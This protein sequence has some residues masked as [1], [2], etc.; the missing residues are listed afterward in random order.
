MSKVKREQSGFGLL[1]VVLSAAVLG[2]VVAGVVGLLNSSL[3]R[4]VLTSE[5]TVAL[6][7]ANEGIELVRAVRD[8]TII[9][10][11]VNDWI[12]SDGVRDALD[13]Q[14][15]TYTT[16]SGQ[17]CR[18]QL[19]DGEESFALGGTTYVRAIEIA[20]PAED[21]SYVRRAGLDLLGV[22]D[23]DVI[24]Q[25]RVTVSWGDASRSSIEATSYLTDWRSE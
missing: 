16:V 13:S 14:K 15:L 8:T 22:T 17:C 11:V 9:D 19:E 7:L 21:S 6:Q 5:R 4:S 23:A 1:E 10:G 20:V 24:R 12:G 2:L 25:V 18:W 3:R